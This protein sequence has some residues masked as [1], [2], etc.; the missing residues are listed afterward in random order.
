PTAPSALGASNITDTTVDLSWTAST[1]A[2]GVTDYL[3]YDNGTL[4]ATT[5]ST[6]TTYQVTGLTPETAYNLTVRAVDAAANESADSNAQAFSTTAPPDNTAP[7]AINDLAALNITDTTVDL[8]WSE[9]NDNVGV[10]GYEVF[11]NGTSIGTT[12]GAT[13]FN[14]IGLNAVTPYAFTVFAEDAA[15]NV[16]LVSNPVN[17]N[18]TF[19]HYTTENANMTSIDWQARDINASRDILVNRNLGIGTINPIYE[20]NV[21]GTINASEILVNGLPLQNSSIWNQSG[22]DIFYNTGNVGIGTNN[23]QGYRLA[24]AGNVIAESM[25]VELQVNWPDFV[26]TKNYGLPSLETVEQHILEKGHLLNIPSAKDVAENG[27]DLGEMN[28]KLLQKIEELTL[29]TIQQ[30]KRINNLEGENMKMELLMQRL[31]ALE[32]QLKDKE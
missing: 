23:T 22:S 10:T 24:V 4:L 5:G 21:D 17:I 31:I 2:V 12:L 26:F 8:I 27:L 14:V 11:Q 30:E 7:D 1:D 13:T 15:G 16:S 32:K 6:A 19:V 9:P 29:Y 18:T 28:A 3:V 20:L 25:K